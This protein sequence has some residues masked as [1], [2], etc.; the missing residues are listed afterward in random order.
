M[1]RIRKV[2]KED[3]ETIVEMWRKDLIDYHLCLKRHP[4]IASYWSFVPGVDKIARAHMKRILNS[5]KYIFLVAVEGKKIVGYT[6]VIIKK[7]WRGF[8]DKKEVYIDELAVKTG[9]R[10]KGV[11]SRLLKE[12]EKRAKK[13]GIKFLT[14][15]ADVENLKTLKFYKKH[16]FEKYHVQMVKEVG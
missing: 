13:L 16:K 7:R 10:G 6:K 11:G 2:S 12:I 14:L 8:S 9:Y 4:V 5:K 3:I 1:I 15:E